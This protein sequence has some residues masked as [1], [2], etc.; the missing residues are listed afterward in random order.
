MFLQWMAT[1]FLD[2][3]SKVF[4]LPTRSMLFMKH[5]QC[6]IINISRLTDISCSVLGSAQPFSPNPGPST[7]IPIR[8]AIKTYQRPCSFFPFLRG[9][10]CCRCLRRHSSTAS[11]YRAWTSLWRGKCRWYGCRG[12][13]STP[14]LP[15]SRLTLAEWLGTNLG[16]KMR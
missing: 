15:P 13:R 3:E 14:S 11:R 9:W 12:K 16:E 5:H 7:D 6:A 2:T 1:L 8:E 4:P 10:I